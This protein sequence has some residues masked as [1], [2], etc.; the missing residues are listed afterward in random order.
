MT[1]RY[2]L[3]LFRKGRN[4]DISNCPFCGNKAEIEDMGKDGARYVECIGCG[5][6]SHSFYPDKHMSKADCDR[7][8]SERWN[9]R[10]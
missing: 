8:L 4:M 10:I 1:K 9:K 6:R 7:G 3:M 2:G 5:A